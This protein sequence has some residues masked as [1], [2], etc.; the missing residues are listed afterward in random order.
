MGKRYPQFI[1]GFRDRYGRM[2]FYFRRG[3]ISEPVPSPGTVEFTEVYGKLLAES[4]PD[5]PRRIGV[6]DK[7]T[8]AWVIGQYKAS[9]QYQRLKPATKEVYERI[10]GWLRDRYGGCLLTTLREQHVRHIRNELK[11]RP[12]VADHTVEKIGMLWGFAKE[13]LEMNLGPNPAAEVAAIHTEHE[14]A[15]AWP[16][17]LCQKFEA[18]PHPRLVL[19]YDLMRYTGQRRSDI[20]QM[21]WKR[22]DGTAIELVQEKTGTF[23]WVPCHPILKTKLAQVE[24]KRPYILTTKRGTPFKAGSVTKMIGL[25]CE[26]LGFPGY[27]PHGLRHLAGAELAEAGCS[28]HEIMSI[29]GHLTEKEAAGYVKQAQRKKMAQSG[30]DKWAGRGSL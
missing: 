19:A 23:V 27:S 29:L 24:R 26:E 13:H 15:K 17:E 28:M 11:E 16:A 1:N 9:K 25:A 12:S 14:S 4:E 30:M 8:M 18:L 21:T 5:R 7:G 22:F 2:R 20:V 6:P 3:E 10:F